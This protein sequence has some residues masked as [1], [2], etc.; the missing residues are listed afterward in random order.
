M[1]RIARALGAEDAAAGLYDLAK[2]VGAPLALRDIGFNEG[3]I[4]RATSI[5][6][7][8]PYW[9]PREIEADGIRRLLSDAHAGRRPETLEATD[10]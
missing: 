5:A 3:D 8:N 10:S 4:D 6:T 2:A 7:G 1:A 9:N